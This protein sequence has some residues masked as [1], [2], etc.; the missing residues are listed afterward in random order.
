M[1]KLVP[2][3]EGKTK[4]KQDYVIYGWPQRY[5][6]VKTNFKWVPLE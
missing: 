2:M 4:E 3:G 1:W 6:H 5:G